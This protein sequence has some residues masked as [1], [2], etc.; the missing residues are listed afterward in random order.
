M[1]RRWTQHIASDVILFYSRR[2]IYV[3]IK[4]SA[5]PRSC[6]R[7]RASHLFQMVHLGLY[8][9]L[10]SQYTQIL[11]AYSQPRPPQHSRCTDGLVTDSR[12]IFT[13]SGAARV[14]LNMLALDDPL[15][16]AP[17]AP[18]RHT[19]LPYSNL[20]KSLNSRRMSAAKMHDMHTHM[21]TAGGRGGESR[22]ST[23]PGSSMAEWGNKYG[24]LPAK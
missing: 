7:F 17:P 16:P 6:G 8:T 10:A 4:Y 11:I 5:R 22:P 20:C 18:P 9:T 23:H 12:L 14:S 13:T 21:H 19:L 2:T 15:A 3:I 24:R 1:G